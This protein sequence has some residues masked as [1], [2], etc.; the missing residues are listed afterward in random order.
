MANLSKTLHIN[1]YQN[2]SSIVEVMIKKCWCVF[3]ASQCRKTEQNFLVN[4]FLNYTF[5]LEHLLAGVLVNFT[6]CIYL[7]VFLMELFLCPVDFECMLIWYL[8]YELNVMSSVTL[9]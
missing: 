3:Y 4:T 9:T 6:S 2:Q 1:F 8:L 5:I 7:L